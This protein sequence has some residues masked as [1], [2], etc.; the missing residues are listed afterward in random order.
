MTRFMGPPSKSIAK[1]F[2]IEF[3]SAYDKSTKIMS[4]FYKM[5]ADLGY[6]MKIKYC[7]YKC[8]SSISSYIDKHL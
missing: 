3:L 6:V 7:A 2:T 8:M 4:S 1:R 5:A